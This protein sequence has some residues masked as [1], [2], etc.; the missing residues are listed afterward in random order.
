MAKNKIFF[1]VGLGIFIV[2]GIALAVSVPK[3]KNLTVVQK[4]LTKISLHW[5]KVDNADYYQVKVMNNNNGSM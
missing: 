4:Y 3:V 1:L 5:K 2:A